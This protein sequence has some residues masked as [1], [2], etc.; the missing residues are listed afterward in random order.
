MFGTLGVT[1][2]PG[3]LAAPVNTL[4]GTFEKTWSEPRAFAK[5]FPPHLQDFRTSFEPAGFIKSRFPDG[6]RGLQWDVYF[7][8]PFPAT[9]QIFS[10]P[11]EPAGFIQTTFRD[12]WCGAQWE[13]RFAT[14]FPP[15]AQSFGASSGKGF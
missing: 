3:I 12:G 9:Q 14:T 10:P 1:P 13:S 4:K 15:A 2:P 8:K 11:F 6:A 5:P 7:V